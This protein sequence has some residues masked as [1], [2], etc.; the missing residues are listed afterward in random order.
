M[1]TARRCARILGPC[2]DIGV[3]VCV[4]PFHLQLEKTQP[5][6][7]STQPQPT[8]TRGLG[9]AGQ[10][11]LC[12]QC[13]SW[14]CRLPA[15]RPSS[16]RRGMPSPLQGTLLLVRRR[17]HPRIKSTPLPSVHGNEAA[18]QRNAPLA[19]G[20]SCSVRSAGRPSRALAGLNWFS[21]LCWLLQAHPTC[22]AY[23]WHD[24]HQPGYALDCVGRDDGHYTTNAENGHFSG[25]DGTA[26]PGR[27]GPSPSPAPPAGP[28]NV[29]VATVRS[30]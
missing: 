24:Q 18:K 7:T 23:T 9:D 6:S 2:F 27:P 25:H 5:S 20:D 26:T 11:Q 30:T 8:R 16:Q 21:S 13:T 14:Q 10:S 15:P 28:P 3:H 22:H 4:Q 17:F 19:F 29:Y 12:V 1:H